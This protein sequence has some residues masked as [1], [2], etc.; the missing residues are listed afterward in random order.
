MDASNSRTTADA[1]WPPLPRIEAESVDDLLKGSALRH[2]ETVAITA[3]GAA[4]DYVSLVRQAEALATWLTAQ[5][6]PGARVA[7]IL[8]NV[9]AQP[10]AMLGVLMAGM[11]AVFANPLYTPQEMSGILQ[12]SEASCAIVFQPLSHRLA[13]AL[14]EAA[15]RHIISVDPGDHL[16]WKKPVV[17]WVARRKLGA[18][19]HRIPGAFS[20]HKV[21]RTPTS[22]LDRLRPTRANLDSPAVMLYS[23]GT[24]GRPKGVPLTHRA[25]LFGIAQ[26]RSALAAHLPQGEPYTLLLAIPLCHILGI[27][28]LLYALAR[29]GTTALAMNARDTPSLLGEWRRHDVSH[30]PAVNT[31]L[32]ALLAAP[33]FD[34]LNFRGLKLTFAAGMPLG[35]ATAQRWRQVTGCHVTEA[36]GLTE[37]N[38]VACNP[39]GQSRPGSVGRVLPGIELALRDDANIVSE[40]GPDEVC[41]RGPALTLGYWRNPQEHT[42]AFTPDG[43]FRTGDIATLDGDGYLRL[44]DRKKDMIIS[45]G[46]KVFPTEVERVLN[47]HPAVLES[48][49]IPMRDERAGEV[50]IAYIVAT[51]A[52]LGPEQLAVFC[53]QSLAS[54]K[55]PRRF[56]FCHEL[57]KSAVGKI[58]RRELRDR[59]P[60]GPQC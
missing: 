51:D 24:T 42:A 12:D 15:I 13:G 37:T 44:V 59:P 60:G 58:L 46:F 50:P 19:S 29:G 54:Y 55:R 52:S 7:I 3:M 57:P 2:P 8:P 47:S 39:P 20:W 4:L 41:V 26:Q 49:V 40:S 36:Y 33:G 38:L 35:E 14:G 22:D 34:R 23:G 45:A 18:P 21:L 17:N 1:A 48:A 11:T 16:G 53:E 56:H 6:P 9:L 27:G 31:L 10:V 43:Y 25:L 32:N 28:S 5:L 30:F